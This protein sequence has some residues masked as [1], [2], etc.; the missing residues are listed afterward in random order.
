M[1]C[2]TSQFTR[3]INAWEMEQKCYMPCSLVCSL[4]LD[5]R[6]SLVIFM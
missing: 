5:D 4:V 3:A 1:T 2:E 6:M